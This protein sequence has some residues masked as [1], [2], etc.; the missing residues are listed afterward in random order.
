[1]QQMEAI[2]PSLLCSYS[3]AFFCGGGGVTVQHE[4]LVPPPGIELVILAPGM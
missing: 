1:M 3:V 4:V 2:V